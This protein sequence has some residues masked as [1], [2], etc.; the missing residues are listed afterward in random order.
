MHAVYN[1]GR[2]SSPM[3][4]HPDG[5]QH[6]KSGDAHPFS[7]QSDRR[8]RAAATEPATAGAGPRR[9]AQPDTP[10]MD[11]GF[12]G[13]LGVGGIDSSVENSPSAAHP[14]RRG[15]VL[16]RTPAILSSIPCGP[17]FAG[18]LNTTLVDR[19][20]RAGTGPR[21]LGCIGARAGASALAGRGP[22]GSDAYHPISRPGS[23]ANKR[24]APASWRLS[25]GQSSA[26]LRPSRQRRSRTL[27]AA[28]WDRAT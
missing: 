13:L 12:R 19:A 3:G 4:R 24:P 9:Y 28:A 26:R 5:Y 17:Q 25:S 21:G 23:F 20:A 6:P 11:D 8:G 2:R 14:N 15:Q 1:R 7:H 22:V 16:R 10:A 27:S 18:R